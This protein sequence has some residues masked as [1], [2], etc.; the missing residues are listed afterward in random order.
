[1]KKV[2]VVDDSAA[3]RAMIISSIESLGDME[4]TEASNGFEALRILPHQVFDLIITDI[5]MPTINGLE[6]INFVKNKAEYKD[7][8]VIV[9]TTEKAH[10]D[11]DKG[12]AL[13]ASAYITKPFDP[14]HLQ[15]TVIKLVAF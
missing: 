5:N 8:P 1:M 11:R 6:I 15:E 7:I 9:V 10:K 12:L 2:L 3:M 4:I 14:V 13:G